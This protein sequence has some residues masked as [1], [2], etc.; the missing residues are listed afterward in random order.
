VVS[1]L[2][3][4][5]WQLRSYFAGIARDLEDAATVD[6]ATRLEAFLLIELP[7][8]LPGLIAVAMFMFA[9]AWNEYL[10][11]SV[12]LY[13]PANQTLSVGLATQLISQFSLYSWGVLM[14][15]AAL[16]TVPPLVLF[17]FMHK[18]LVAGLTAGAVRG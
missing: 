14:A 4:A 18:R 10:F 13:T 5:V 6:G 12:L 3:F 7:L 2:P 8:A 17:M 9:V 15:G 1:F 16:M 11:A